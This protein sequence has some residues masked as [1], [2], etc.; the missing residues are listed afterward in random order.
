MFQTKVLSKMKPYYLIE[1]PFPKIVPFMTKC[2]KIWYSQEGQ[3]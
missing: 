2:G 1:E 3:R